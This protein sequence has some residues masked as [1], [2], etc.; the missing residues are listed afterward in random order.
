MNRRTYLGTIAT[1]V[2]GLAT[3]G[4]TAAESGTDGVPG[5]VSTRGHFDIAWGEEYLTDG[6]DET[7]YDVDGTIPGLSGS[8]PDEL[9]VMLH[10]YNQTP[11]E[12]REDIIEPAAAGFQA[13]GYDGPVVGYTWDSKF[14]NL[15]W[16][17][18]VEIAEQNGPKLAAYCR[19]YAQ[20]NPGTALRVVGHSL[21]AEVIL[22]AIEQLD[23]WGAHDA[24][25]T[26]TMLGAA[27]NDEAPSLD[28]EPFE[29]TYGEEIERSVGR[30]DNFYNT[31]DETLTGSYEY[32]EW[33]TALGAEG[34][35]EEPPANYVDHDVSYVDG[36]ETYFLADGGCVDAV[37]DTWSA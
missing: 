12:A 13:G 26:V 7:D 33:D 32:A 4:T 8:A 6:H 35:E 9:V 34:I 29:D 20:K 17:D 37:V 11:A 24:I 3:A 2:A 27:V 21:G 36:H 19:D 31:S 5:Y 18:T 30:F 1:G 15:Q 25:D 14:S 22:N 28:W 10:G 16:W 23:D